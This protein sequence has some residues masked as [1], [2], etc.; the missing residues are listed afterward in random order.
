MP[1]ETLIPLIKPL[2]DGL[3]AVKNF[4]RKENE[5]SKA[6]GRGGKGGSGSIVDG[7]GLIIGGRGGRGGRPNGGRG[8]DG[9]SG[10]IKGGNGLIIGGDGGEAAQFGRPGLGAQSP[11]DRLGLGNIILPD[12]RRLS[13]F[14]RGGDGGGPP[15]QHE[16]KLYNLATLIRDLPRATIYEIDE[17]RPPSAQEWWNRFVLQRPALAAEVVAKAEPIH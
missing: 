1:F 9:G 11:L 10:T 15:I 3:R 12:G 7:T 13:D 16:G 6:D 4:F 5:E 14:G 8:G 2:F 17:T